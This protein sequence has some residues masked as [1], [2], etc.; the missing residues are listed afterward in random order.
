M[1]AFGLIQKGVP[2]CG[3]H[4]ALML[5][6]LEVGT[7]LAQVKPGL[8]LHQLD[9]AALVPQEVLSGSAPETAAVRAVTQLHSMCSTVGTK[10]VCI[11]SCADC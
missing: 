2:Q 4:G 5:A 3:R 8:V 1:G 9:L 6:P 10:P 7:N 11:D